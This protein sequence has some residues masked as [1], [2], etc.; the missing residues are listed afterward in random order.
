[1]RVVTATN[2]DLR[3][4]VSAGRF[5]EDLYFRLGGAIVRVPPLRERPRELPVLAR[6]LLA[7]ACERLSREVPAIGVR[8]TVWAGVGLLVLATMIIGYGNSL[9]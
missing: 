2:R 9:G 8:A 1:M 7:Q 3:A 4:E 6:E 5:R